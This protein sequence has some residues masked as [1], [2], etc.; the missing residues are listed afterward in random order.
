VTQD[1][2]DKAKETVLPDLGTQIKDDIVNQTPEG[3]F[4][5]EDS[6]E[7]Q[8]PEINSSAQPGEKADKFNLSAKVT[9][10]AFVFSQTDASALIDKSLAER[11]GDKKEVVSGATFEYKNVSAFFDKGQVVFRIQGQQPLVWK[12]N[13]DEIKNLILGKKEADV[14]NILSERPEIQSAQVSFWPFWVSK[15]PTRQE[16]IELKIE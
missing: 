16:K 2:L 11:V 5:L 3:F 12:I 14:R 15:I 7:V 8:E 6:I 9:A 4:I 1:D 10:R 13:N